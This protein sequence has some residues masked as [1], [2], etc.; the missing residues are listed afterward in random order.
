MPREFPRHRRVAELIQH[1]IAV[2][3]Q[4]EFSDPGAVLVTVSSVDV[5]PDLRNAKIFVTALGDADSR[6]QLVKHLN[7]QAGHFRHGLGQVLRLRT[8]PH[9]KFIYD[10]APERGNRI[11]ELLDSVRKQERD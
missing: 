7:Q 1:E 10:E 9:L 11:S 4:R 8:V 6:P 5:S 3:I 2:L